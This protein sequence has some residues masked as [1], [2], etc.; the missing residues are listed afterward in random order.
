[1]KHRFVVALD[2]S[3]GCSRSGSPGRYVSSPLP[4]QILS[5]RALTCFHLWV[6]REDVWH[7]SQFFSFF[8]T[9]A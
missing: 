8:F 6:Q 2:A 4:P 5:L 9:L 3:S 1:M 7:T